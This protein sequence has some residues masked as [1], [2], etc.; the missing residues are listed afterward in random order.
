MWAGRRGNV[1]SRVR[2]A[3]TVPATGY[4]I[5]PHNNNNNNN[6][7]CNDIYKYA[8]V[9]SGATLSVVR[10]ITRTGSERVTRL[11]VRD[12][13][14]LSNFRFFLRPPR[15]SDRANAREDCDDDDN[16]TRFSAGHELARV[17]IVGRRKRKL[18]SPL[19]G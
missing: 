5:F 3:S 7:I 16:R 2:C 17:H 19:D 11:V 12:V 13:E 18:P 9:V 10:V 14:C 6:D 1:R 15:D 8:Y 4:V